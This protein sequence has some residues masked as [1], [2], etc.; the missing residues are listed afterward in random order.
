MK[1][2]NL[3][4]LVKYIRGVKHQEINP[5][6][7]DV[8]HLIIDALRDVS[9][10]IEQVK[11]LKECNAQTRQILTKFARDVLEKDPSN[12]TAIMILDKANLENPHVTKNQ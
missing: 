2:P 12:Q 11:K 5:L 6:P 10:L 1:T 8:Y 9:G 7:P 3:S 4:K